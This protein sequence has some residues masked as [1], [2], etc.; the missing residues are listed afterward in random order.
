[1]PKKA[2]TKKTIPKQTIQ[3]LIRQSRQI[4]K[5]CFLENGAI[6]AANTDKLYYPRQGADYRWVW[7]RDAA[8]VVLA[9]RILGLKFEGAFFDWLW[10]RPQDFA[11]TGLLFANYSTNGRFGSMGRMFEP[12]QNGTI[13]WLIGETYKDRPLPKKTE[14]LVRRLA[15][16]LVNIW[17]GAHFSCHTV[18][19]WE[20]EHRHTTI[21]MA[22]NHT[23]SLAACAKGLLRAAEMLGEGIWKEN[24]LQMISQIDKAYSEKDG[25]FYRNIGKTKDPNVDASMIG[26]A[27]PF[28]IFDYKDSKIKNTI[29]AIEENIV[30]D[31][32][33][34]RYQFDYFDGE[35]SASEGGGAWPLLNFWLSIYFAKAGNIKKAKE[36]FVWP[37]DK[38]APYQGYLPEQIFPDNRIGVYPLSW[39]YAMFVIAAY[40]LG[41]ISSNLSSS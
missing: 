25:Y 13:L 2:I 16:G 35:G 7:P 12:D 30:V 10:E 24:A 33:V 29:K 19:I 36:Y 17:N 34:H 18:D 23:Y 21:T 26:L 28:E 1:M 22:N 27:W 8:F 11:R 39:S 5:D 38:L 6:V 31:G 9:A 3:K 20:E 32:G 15:N 40:H 14:A 37:L 4:F 41:Y